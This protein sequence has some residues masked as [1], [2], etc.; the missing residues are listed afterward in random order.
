MAACG[1]GSETGQF[2]N[3]NCYQ[4]VLSLNPKNLK[5]QANL[6]G[7]LLFAKLYDDA[8][9]AFRLAVALSPADPDLR[10]NLGVALERAGHTAEAQRA[11]A[12][13]ERLKA[14]SG[15]SPAKP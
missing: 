13:A 1:G 14:A 6:A 8:A 3:S 4:R 2:R 15:R 11:N 9:A 7:T 10:T 12:E 5:A